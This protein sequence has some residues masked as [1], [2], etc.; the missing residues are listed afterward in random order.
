MYDCFDPYQLSYS[1]SD[2]DGMA[3]PADSRLSYLEIHKHFSLVVDRLSGGLDTGCDPIEVKRPKA[4]R[5]L[6]DY[7]E[8]AVVRFKNGKR[9]VKRQKALPGYRIRITGALQAKA[10]KDL[11]FAKQHWQR[12]TRRWPMPAQTYPRWSTKFGVGRAELEKKQIVPAYLTDGNPFKWIV[13][14]R[15]AE[16]DILSVLESPSWHCLKAKPCE[17]CEAAR[18]RSRSH[19]VALPSISP[20]RVM[21][22][23][24]A[25]VDIRPQNSPTKP[26]AAET[27]LEE[28]K[29]QP[30]FAK[31]RG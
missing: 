11:E 5:D 18:G 8:T 7:T 24:S 16:S 13:R 15:G 19:N 30:Q 1:Y 4:P 23:R 29:C 20:R 22:R 10:K 31:L 27:R 9:Q 14:Y 2:S 25:A 28:E 6:L 21:G 12:V 3:A 17:I 26:R